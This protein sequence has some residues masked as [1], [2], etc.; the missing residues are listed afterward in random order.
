VYLARANLTGVKVRKSQLTTVQLAQ[1][2][3]VP[4]WVAEDD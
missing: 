2:T 3:G 4:A 1:F